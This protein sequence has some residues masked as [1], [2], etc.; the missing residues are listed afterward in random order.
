MV[1]EGEEG[2]GGEG[3]G[4]AP[5]KQRRRDV[6][7]YLVVGA[8]VVIGLAL[9]FGVHARSAA[10]ARLKQA[11]Q[12]AAR[13]AVT[14]VTPVATAADQELVLPG[15]TQAFITAPINAR[16]NGYLEEWFF[17]I[18]A[19]VK[20]GALL[21]KIAT[22]EVDQQLQQARADLKS[23]EANLAIAKITAERWQA[24]VANGAVSR[25]E[26][27]QA[28]TNLRA[29]RAA[30]DSSSANVRRLENLQSFQKVYAP[31]DG[32]ITA[33]NTDTGALID[34]GAS[35]Q[36]RE[37]FQLADIRTI[38]VYVAVPEVYAQS[39]QPNAEALLMLDEFPGESFHGKIVRNSNAIDPAS[40]TLL[41]EVD[42]DNQDG[43]LMPGAYALVHLKLPKE[44]RSVTIPANTLLFRSEGLRVGV[45]RNGHAEL[46]PIKIGRDYGA[47]VE[48]VAGLEPTD[49]VIVDPPD[50]LISGTPVQTSPQRAK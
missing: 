22:P 27:D 37:L 45:V 31:F 24:L 4:K 43:R 2:S 19:R 25:Q 14:V 38:R 16:T 46:V 34:A 42:V 1:T 10:E 32:V 26:T 5:P 6:K 30:V 35:G 20:R 33:R 47:T 29:A 39:V 36:G 3:G 40:R 21:A 9:Y 23:A 49:A 17:D 12:D 11:T 44:V 15:N 28:S 41:T 7:L 50:S 13:I 8:V 48:V 18:G